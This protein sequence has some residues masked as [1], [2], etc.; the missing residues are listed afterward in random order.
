MIIGLCGFYI[1]LDKGK[2]P[3]F[4]VLD[5][6]HKMLYPALQSGSRREPS[7]KYLWLAL[8][9]TIIQTLTL[10]LPSSLNKNNVIKKWVDSLRW[11]LV[12][13]FPCKEQ[14]GHLSLPFWFYHHGFLLCNIHKRKFCSPQTPHRGVFRYYRVL[15]RQIG[16]T[17]LCRTK[18]LICDGLLF[19]ANN[20]W[21]DCVVL[22][23][24][25][26]TLEHLGRYIFL[27]SNK[28]VHLLT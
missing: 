20:V 25:Q 28:V 1:L 15:L 8:S 17:L 24:V 26:L 23:C 3:K 14:N 7:C 27:F 6:G 22:I 5:T 21:N 13:C 9:S 11:R 18:D 19:C 4:C 2:Y 16:W 12:P 10:H